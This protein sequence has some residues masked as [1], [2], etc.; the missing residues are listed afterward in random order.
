MRS[1]HPHNTSP[2]PAGQSV[3]WSVAPEQLLAAL[4]TTRDGLDPA[5][6]GQRLKRYGLNAL[7][8]QRRVT[9][10]GLF[11]NQFKSPL[12]LILI[13]AASIS[14]IVGEW[15]DAVI[16][17]AVVLGSTLLGFVQEYQASN[18]VEKLRSQVTI[19]SS[20]RRSGQP[21]WLPS[22][23]IVPGDVVLLSAGS[24]IPADGVVLEANDFFVN[25]AVLTGETFP[26]EKKPGMVSAKASLAERINC[27]FM[28]TSVRSGTAQVLI[29]QT[30]KATV[31]GQIA[32]RLS[33]RPPETEFER[34]IH[35][36]GY[37]LTQVML[38][39]V[40][41][42]LAV[43]IFLA[44]PP[45]DSLLFAL[46]LAVGLAPELLP[47][48]ISITLAHGAQRMAKRGVIVRRL[49]AIENFGSMDVLCTDKTGTLTEGVVRLD[50]ALDS[51]GQPSTAV[52][53]STYLNAHYQT[54]LNNPLD[55]AISA[56]ARQS[57]LDI[58][59]EQKIDE[60]PYD[61]VRKRLSVVTANA[62]GERTLITKGA[63]E[64]VLSICPR[65]Q[66]GNEVYPL[67]DTRRAGIEQR[68]SDWSGQGFRVLGVATKTV[69]ARP[70]SYSRADENDLTFAGFLLFFDPPKADVQ[71]AIAD[72][73]QRGVQIKI[74]T[75][76]NEKVARHIAE[77]VHLPV[78]GVLTGSAL[79]DLRDE[80]LWHAAERTTLFAE[81]DP[82]QKER[83][84]LALRKTKHVVGYMGDGI[85]DAPALH[86]ADVGISVDT[87]VDVAKDAADFVLLKQD[88]DILREGIDEGRLTF[89]NTLKY[90]LTT[91]SANF[92]NMFSMAAASLFL[93]FLPLLAS[94]ILLNNFLSDIPGTTIAS[95]NV[96]PEWVVKP[97]RWDT[98]FIR[99][100]MVLFGLVSSIFDM[101]TFGVLLFLFHASPEEFRTGWFIESLLTELVIALVVRTRGLFFRSRPGTL[102]LAS[103]LVVTGIT[104]VLPYL[105]FNFLFGFIPLPAPLML[106]MLGLT[107]LYVVVTEIAKK[108]FYS[109][110]VNA[111]A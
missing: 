9:A 82:N 75:G 30:G 28:G 55:E 47:A 12:V 64:N 67:D 84:I 34:G 56:Y 21:Q 73:A 45:I 3:Y 22:E 106:T 95:D 32:E 51:E 57:G 59:A 25:Q 24:L 89:A 104:L 80:A 78:M 99:N 62:R 103:T 37:L 5:D 54:G 8:A 68:Y 81:V 11:L 27:V 36:F 7:Q 65:V 43:N 17:L 86:A 101:L 87:A 16:V 4:Q 48:I 77:A 102:L 35:N 66:A 40:V 94:Q 41:L 76:D 13:F 46:A 96:D 44:K 19:K 1:A 90:I 93:P 91:V 71:Q 111:T 61:F 92:G 63:L 42:V 60:I 70:D 69:N 15:T 26:I 107:A 110:T 49:N 23:Q 58:S 97:R 2:Q 83:I 38:V 74:I 53:R 98:T 18:A 31:F 105:P 72:L 29:I 85:N 79:N 100:Y 50:G 88:L 20:V 109:R 14:A 6:A 10:F 39:M 108:Y 52:L 33:L